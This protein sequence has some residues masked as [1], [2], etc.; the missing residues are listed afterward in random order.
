[1]EPVAFN[2]RDAL[3]LALYETHP[4]MI[5]A[6][7]VGGGRRTVATNLQMLLNSVFHGVSFVITGSGTG[8]QEALCV[9]WLEGPRTSAVRDFCRRFQNT[10]L[11][12][13]G[14]PIAKPH[15]AWRE[16][17]GSV[18]YVA[19][20]RGYTDDAIDYAIAVLEQRLGPGFAALRATPNK[21]RNRSLDRTMI[22]MPRVGV[23]AAANAIYGV[24]EQTHWETAR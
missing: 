12:R 19:T 8:R 13:E 3:L 23:I 16:A 6:A 10:E 15:D 14:E 20:K 4:F 5:R 18:A 9:E 17:F 2:A 11:G 24:L 7:I 21:L 22:H 1:M